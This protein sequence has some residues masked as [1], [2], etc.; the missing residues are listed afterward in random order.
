MQLGKVIPVTT[1]I[2]ATVATTTTWMGSSTE[3]KFHIQTDSDA[4]SVDGSIAIPKG[5]Y[6]LAK[7]SQS[8][9]S[10]YIDLQI[11]SVQID[12]QEKPIPAE[13]IIVQGKSGEPIRAKV[14]NQ[15]GS[16]GGGLGRMFLAAGLAGIGEAA[17]STNSAKIFIGN[18]TSISNGSNIGAGVAKGVADS[19]SQQI[20]GQVNLTT[21]RPTSNQPVLVLKSGTKLEL[22]INQ[23]LTL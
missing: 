9:S 14:K 13:A 8:N 15:V 18:T 21:R 10:G 16:G 19:L 23:P 1:R 5:T 6:L 12:G 2:K 7:V 11:L 17:N 4:P 20:S 22:I 3:Q